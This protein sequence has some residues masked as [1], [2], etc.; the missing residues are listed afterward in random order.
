MASTVFHY[1]VNF[2]FHGIYLCEDCY[3]AILRKIQFTF[4]EQKKTN[5]YASHRPDSFEVSLQGENTKQSK[6][7]KKV[8]M[9]KVNKLRG[10]ILAISNIEI[11]FTH[12][13]EKKEEIGTSRQI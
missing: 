3:L 11:V 4:E 7:K 13:Y 8:A 9:V 1:V 10:Y 12:K 2:I 6:I 5:R